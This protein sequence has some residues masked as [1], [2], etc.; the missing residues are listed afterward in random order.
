MIIMT[1]CAGYIFSIALGE[2]DPRLSFREFALA[3]P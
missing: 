3:A 2:V 1:G